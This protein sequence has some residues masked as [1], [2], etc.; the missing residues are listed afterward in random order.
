MRIHIQVPMDLVRALV[1][2]CCATLVACG[3]GGGGGDGG[4]G[5]T[6]PPVPVITPPSITQQTANQSVTADTQV[7]FSVV[8]TGEGTLSYQWQRDGV[9]VA[10]ATTP[11]HAFIA[12]TADT[13]PAGP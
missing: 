6:P 1:L 2:S 11:Q 10:G 5:T 4:G 8:A 13:D 7:T 12:R 3:G 9:D